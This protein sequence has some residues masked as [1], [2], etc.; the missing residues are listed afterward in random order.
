[1]NNFGY[2]RAMTQEDPT[3]SFG[4]S[5][6]PASQKAAR[7]RDVF[8]RV[9]SRY[10][11]MNDVMSGGLHRVWKQHMIRRL[12]LHHISRPLTMIDMAGGTGDISFRALNTRAGRAG[13]LNVQLMDIN[14]EMLCV[15]QQRATALGHSI[16]VI[17]ASAEHI[18]C[19]DQSVDIFTIAFGIRNVTDR[20][21]ALREAYRV[22]RPGGIFACLEFSHIPNDMLAG[23]YDKYSFSLIPPIGRMI[24]GSDAP[25][26]YLVE[27]IRMFPT[28]EAFTSEIETAG[29]A[30][31]RAERLSA[32]IVALHLGWRIAP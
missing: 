23:L 24:T 3:T 7:V 30:R 29:F 1:M 4:F 32:G 31:V 22:L 11:I 13:Q 2:R 28:A 27:S 6:I 20:A 10:D 19:A 12:P 25:Y 8:D 26:Q 16:D 17:E 14:H 18:P 5:Q 15:G 9:A 21:Q